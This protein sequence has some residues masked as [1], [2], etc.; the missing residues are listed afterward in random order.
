VYNKSARREL[1]VAQIEQAKGRHA[2]PN[3]VRSRN[4]TATPAVIPDAPGL[5]LYPTPLAATTP[6]ELMDVLRLYWVWAGRPSYRVMAHQCGLR[7]AAATL[8]AA[9]HSNQLPSFVMIQT[10]ITACGGSSEH[11]RDF[12]T[13]WRRLEMS[14]EQIATTSRLPQRLFP[15]PGCLVL[16]ESKSLVKEDSSDDDDR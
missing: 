15:K 8:H 3:L 16:V 9:L 7:F 6:A 5:D 11:L 1:A 10:I 4:V 2:L 14:R 13:A 12:A